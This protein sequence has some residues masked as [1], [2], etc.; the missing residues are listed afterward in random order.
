MA[1]ASSTP[2]P[3]VEGEQ[4][5]DEFEKTLARL[6]FTLDSESAADTCAH[7]HTVTLYYQQDCDGKDEM[8]MLPENKSK[9]LHWLKVAG[10]VNCVGGYVSCLDHGGH[11]DNIRQYGYAWGFDEHP[12]D[13]DKPAWVDEDSLE[14]EDESGA[15]NDCAE[16]K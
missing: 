15:K 6:G 4:T 1:A 12:L 10:C 2:P 7:D 8:K 11:Y 14:S 5:P 13:P 16:K 9:H 3:K